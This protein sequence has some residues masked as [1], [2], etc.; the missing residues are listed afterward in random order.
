MRSSWKNEPNSS[1]WGVKRKCEVWSVGRE[2]SG[3]GDVRGQPRFL[4]GRT[5]E[6]P[7]VLGDD[8]LAG[9]WENG[10]KTGREGDFM[11][12]MIRGLE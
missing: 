2:K 4:G 11:S 12:N 3:R 1:A 7:A 9:S 8:R 10:L 6:F 5:K